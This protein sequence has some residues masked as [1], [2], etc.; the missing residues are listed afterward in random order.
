MAKEMTLAD[1]AEAWCKEQ[2]NEVPARDSDEWQ[3][4][5]ETWATWAF[6]DLRGEKRPRRR[7]QSKRLM[8]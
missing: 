7:R 4:M 3:R 1:H 6:S 8:S 2:G 5:Y